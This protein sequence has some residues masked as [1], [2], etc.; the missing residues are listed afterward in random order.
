[1]LGARLIIFS[2][3]DPLAIFA[4]GFINVLTGSSQPREHIDPLVDEINANFPELLN[5]FTSYK[6][7]PHTAGTSSL[8]HWIRVTY[9]LQT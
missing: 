8:S 1:M 9:Y 6:F 4:I 2:G 5:L 7:T 3:P